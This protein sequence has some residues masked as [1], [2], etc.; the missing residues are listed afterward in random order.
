MKAKASV[1]PAASANNQLERQSDGD[2]LRQFGVLYAPDYVINAGSVIAISHEGPDSGLGLMRRE[3]TSFGE[4]M[5]LIFKRAEEEGKATSEFADA[6]A[7]EQLQSPRL[8][9][10]AA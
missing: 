3:V 7:E 2:V 4:T 1:E 5:T 6:I 10:D 9:A 8:Y